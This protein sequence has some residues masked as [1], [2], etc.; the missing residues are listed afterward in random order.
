M[1]I[2]VTW[3][4]LVLNSHHFFVALLTR[5]QFSNHHTVMLVYVWFVDVRPP[6][7]VTLI[8]LILV[9]RG[10]SNIRQL[11]IAVTVIIVGSYL[12]LHVVIG[13]H[14]VVKSYSALSCLAPALPHIITDAVDVNN[15]FIVSAWMCIDLYKP[16][17]SSAWRDFWLAIGICRQDYL[18]LFTTTDWEV[19]CLVLLALIPVHLVCRRWVVKCTNWH[20]LWCRVI[21]R[22]LTLAL[23]S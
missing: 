19:S 9:L 22:T 20:D 14:W 2:I 7:R 3:R 6:H 15:A 11:D 4:A 1:Q 8:V 16:W 23:R 21:H 5:H 12:A 18:F 10:S 17:I 13:K